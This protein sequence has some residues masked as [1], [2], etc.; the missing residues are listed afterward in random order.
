MPGNKQSDEANELTRKSIALPERSQEETF[1]GKL[2]S[3]VINV[4]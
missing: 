3:G 1:Q 4:V 2:C